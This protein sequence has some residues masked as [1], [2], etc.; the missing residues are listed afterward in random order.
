MHTD[1]FLFVLIF[2][3]PVLSCGRKIL[4]CAACGFSVCRTAK[5]Y[6]T[7]RIGKTPNGE[8]G[9]KSSCSAYAPQLPAYRIDLL[10]Y[11]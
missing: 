9:N 3:I 7:I 11:G 2:V 6:Y 1:S 5:V 8:G 4:P 10:V